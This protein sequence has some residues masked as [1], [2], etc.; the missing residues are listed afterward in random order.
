MTL[1]PILVYS[2]PAATD[3]DD[4][5]AKAGPKHM[6]GLYLLYIN[7]NIATLPVL[8]LVKQTSLLSSSRKAQC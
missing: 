5:C 4:K 7:M 8:S 1:Q 6:L 3:S 2:C